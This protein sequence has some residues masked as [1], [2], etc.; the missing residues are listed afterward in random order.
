MNTIFKPEQ[1]KI[2]IDQIMDQWDLTEDYINRYTEEDGP[3]CAAL[4][5]LLAYSK[6]DGE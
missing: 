4:K 5:A 6:V 2:I 1:A 3:H